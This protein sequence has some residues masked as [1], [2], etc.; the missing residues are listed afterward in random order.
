[1]LRA[2]LSSV[3][4]VAIKQPDK[5]EERFERDAE[6]WLLAHVDALDRCTT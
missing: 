3:E 5:T 2:Y 6:G 1:M 4:L